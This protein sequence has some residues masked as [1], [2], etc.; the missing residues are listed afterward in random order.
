MDLMSEKMMNLSRKCKLSKRTTWKFKIENST[1]EM[2][3]VKETDN[4]RGVSELEK[5]STE[6]TQTTERKKPWRC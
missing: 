1:S 6:S 4:C 3:I 5:R 2:R